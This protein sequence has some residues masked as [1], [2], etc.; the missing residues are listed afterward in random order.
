MVRPQIADRTA[1]HQ[2][3]VLMQPVFI[4]LIDNIRKELEQSP[5]TG[6]YREEPIWSDNVP[7]ELR[8]RVTALH[9]QL[10]TASP[11]EVR[12]LEATLA[13]LPQPL[14]GYFLCLEREGTPAI[15][16]DLWQ[17]CYQI[18]FTNY[19][20][21]LH[22]GEQVTV[23]VDTALLDANGEVDWNR[24]DEKARRIVRE[25]FRSLGEK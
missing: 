3:E 8:D 11:Q 10:K 16:L 17:V 19:N 18:C 4:R 24:L 12:E 1:W 15:T 13:T 14:P 5:W 21:L 2:A 23:Q 22:Q 9:A 20:P 6:N 7:A 25:I